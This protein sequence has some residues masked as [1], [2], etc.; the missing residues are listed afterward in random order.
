M[1]AFLRCFVALAI[2]GLPGI[3]SSAAGAAQVHAAGICE[4]SNTWRIDQSQP[5]QFIQVGPGVYAVNNSS[6]EIVVHEHEEASGTIGTSVDASLGASANFIVAEVHAQTGLTVSAS[7][8]ISTG[9][10]VDVP[11]APHSRVE[12]KFG[13]F[14]LKRHWHHE[15][16]YYCP[17]RHQDLNWYGWSYTPRRVGYIVSNV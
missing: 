17:P 15:Y 7:L 3:A 1:K 16:W 12:V 13:V 9:F 8:T 2:L 11:V 10:S 6:R 4:S 14:R 5:D